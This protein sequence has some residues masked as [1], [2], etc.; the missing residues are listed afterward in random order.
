MRDGESAYL[1]GDLNVL[2]FT[3]IRAIRA[4]SP[5]LKL[6]VK[7]FDFGFYTIISRF[8]IRI[9]P[10]SGWIVYLSPVKTLFWALGCFFM[11]NQ[12]HKGFQGI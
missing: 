1:V 8:L 6:I 12:S 2:P 7:I 5:Y 4:I 9:T 10:F 11:K 3:G